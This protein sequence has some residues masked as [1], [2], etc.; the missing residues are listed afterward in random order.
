MEQTIKE[1]EAEFEFFK[2]MVTGK[3]HNNELDGESLERM[4]E[5]I[6]WIGHFVGR[7]RERQYQEAN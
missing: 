6:Y 4:M 7:W 2:Q 1:M 5:N 3:L